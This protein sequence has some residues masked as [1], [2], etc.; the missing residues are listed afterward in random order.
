[1]FIYK[2]HNHNKKAHKKRKISH[3]YKIQDFFKF[4]Q[5][6]SLINYFQKF[7]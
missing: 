7:F 6:S 1:M 3:I 4:I 2:K 5:K